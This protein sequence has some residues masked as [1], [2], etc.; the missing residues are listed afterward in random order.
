MIS[1]LGWGQ[2]QLGG[3]LDADQYSV[4][5]WLTSCT[6]AKGKG[7][8]ISHW[9]LAS[10]LRKVS[11][12][13]ITYLSL[14]QYDLF[15]YTRYIMHLSSYLLFSISAFLIARVA[16]LTQQLPR[17]NAG[18]QIYNLDGRST[19]RH[20][21]AVVQYCARQLSPGRNTFL[22][23][24]YQCFRVSLHSKIL[25]GFFPW[26]LTGSPLIL[27]VPNSDQAIL[28]LIKKNCVF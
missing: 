21:P 24:M 4:P 15:S 6:T 28:I 11:Q 7:K 5:I 20:I 17:I 14:Q 26:L 18:I 12:L 19:S 3:Q 10:Y 13:F 25:H 27:S 9:Y 1:Q 8:N 22:L 16:L 2:G 23:V